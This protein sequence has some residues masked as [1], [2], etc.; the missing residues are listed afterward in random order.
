[1]TPFQRDEVC[2]QR[3]T[4]QRGEEGAEGEWDVNEV[5]RERTGVDQD[6]G[7]GE[8]ERERAWE[9]EYASERCARQQKAGEQK[10]EAQTGLDGRKRVHEARRSQGARRARSTSLIT[11]LRTATMEIIASGFGRSFFGALAEPTNIS[12]TSNCNN[13]GCRLPEVRLFIV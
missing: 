7:A 11:V 13:A 4:T 1:M 6:G 5:E 2:N 9:L 10:R 12:A 3:S 8:P